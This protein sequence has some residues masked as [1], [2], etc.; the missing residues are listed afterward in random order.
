MRNEA[1]P[2]SARHPSRH[3]SVHPFLENRAMSDLVEG[4]CAVSDLGAS[5]M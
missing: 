3:P 5:N 2:E 4:W 1:S